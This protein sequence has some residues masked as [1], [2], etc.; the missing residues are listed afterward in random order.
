MYLYA[1]SKY[2]SK[3]LN[4]YK[5]GK[6]LENLSCRL[7]LAS[8]WWKLSDYTS[9]IL[10]L[11][12]KTSQFLAKI[13][14]YHKIAPR[15]KL[16]FLQ[17]KPCM[18]ISKGDPITEQWQHQHQIWGAKGEQEKCLGGKWKKKCAQNVQK[19]AISMLKLSNLG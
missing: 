15:S 11:R 2:S 13:T 1:E 8:A 9:I 7:H 10:L 5:F 6:S 19:F 4:S 16:N 18:S 12:G 14:F 3:N 17:T